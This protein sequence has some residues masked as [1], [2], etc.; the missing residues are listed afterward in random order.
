MWADANA[1]RKALQG[2][3]IASG[4]SSELVGRECGVS[5]TTI[6]C[7]LDGSQVRPQTLA[8]ICANQHLINY[9]LTGETKNV[10]NCTYAEERQAQRLA[11]MRRIQAER[12]AGKVMVKVGNNC[13]VLRRPDDVER[14]MIKREVK[15]Y[16]KGY[17]ERQL[18]INKE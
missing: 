17:E 9:E 2:Y 13:W 12:D 15:C 16:G 10:K 7:F 3:M 8:S 11:E 5:D 14:G 6:R 1:V 4:K 18:I